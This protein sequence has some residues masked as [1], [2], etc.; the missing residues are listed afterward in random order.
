MCVCVCAGHRISHPCDGNNTNKNSAL[1]LGA[2]GKFAC[3]WNQLLNFG[4]YFIGRNCFGFLFLSCTFC[5]F[6]AFAHKQYE[7]RLISRSLLISFFIGK[8]HSLFSHPLSYSFLWERVSHHFKSH[9]H[10]RPHTEK[11]FVFCTIQQHLTTNDMQNSLTHSLTRFIYH[12]SRRSTR[13]IAI[14]GSLVCSVFL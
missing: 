14:Y 6:E 3:K 7:F 10:P 2:F 1:V 4:I 12:H 11:L 5:H 9:T 13:K 8:K